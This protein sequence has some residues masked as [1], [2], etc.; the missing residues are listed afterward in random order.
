MTRPG[1]YDP[2]EHADALGIRVEWGRPRT[3]NGLW[4]P[5][6]NL[7]ILKKGMRVLLERSVLAHEIGHAALGHRDTTPRNERRADAFAARNLITLPQLAY[8]ADQSRDPGQWCI[9]LAVTPH[10]LETYLA[11]CQAA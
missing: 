8:A 11:Q 4:V 5:D 10:I 9:D 3:A 2:F 6:A 1:G 7:I